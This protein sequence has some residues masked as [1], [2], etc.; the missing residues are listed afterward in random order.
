MDVSERLQFLHK[1]YRE[2]AAPHFE[3]Y[4]Q[5]SPDQEK[6]VLTALALRRNQQKN[7]STLNQLQELYVRSEQAL[8]HLEKRGLLVSQADTYAL[9]NTS[10]GDWIC[11]EITN[12]LQDPQDYKNWLKSNKSTL[13]RF[14]WRNKKN[15]N[16]I[17]PRIGPK[18]RELIIGWVS[19]PRN[20][21]T[22][23]ELLKVAL[24]I[25]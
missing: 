16:A 8:G 3:D 10:F 20:L 14:S 19:D 22:V 6:I 25:R 12:T 2:Q 4:W 1:K 15:L 23:A 11:G 9:F 7:L 24:S 13:G 21:L 5:H 17:L 18:Y